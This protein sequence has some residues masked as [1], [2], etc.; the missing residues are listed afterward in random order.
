MEESNSILRFTRN[1]WLPRGVGVAQ[2]WEHSPP[3]DVARDRFSNSTQYVCGVCCWF[4]SLLR[5]VFFRV[6]RFSPLFKNQHFQILIR[7]DFSWR[8]ATMW[9]CHCK[10]LIYSILNGHFLSV[11]IYLTSLNMYM[12]LSSYVEVSSENNENC[13][14][15]ASLSEK[16]KFAR[17]VVL[18][19]CFQWPNF[20]ILKFSCK[21]WV[22]WK[23][24]PQTPKSKTPKS[25]KPK[26]Q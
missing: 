4:S 15:L 22:S 3:T 18:H 8:I 12:R 23:L 14:K 6:L 7:P 20:V 26:T 9:R 1:K 25:Q 19:E 17:S 16:E 21:Q 10:F 13:F 2:W 24:R 5:E 11:E